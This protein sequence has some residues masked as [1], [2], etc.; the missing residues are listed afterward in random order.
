MEVEGAVS[1]R[2]KAKRWLRRTFRGKPARSGEARYPSGN[3]R[4]GDGLTRSSVFL[5][6]EISWPPRLTSR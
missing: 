4:I 1:N 2:A 3:V 6:G 5:P